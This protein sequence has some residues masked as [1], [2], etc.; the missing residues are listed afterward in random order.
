MSLPLRFIVVLCML[1]G[2]VFVSCGSSDSGNRVVVQIPS[3]PKTLHPV[4]GYDA[5]RLL[6][7]YY[8]HQ[9]MTMLD[10]ISLEHMPLLARDLPVVSEDR[11]TYSYEVAPDATWHDGAPITAADVIF[12]IKAAMCPLLSNVAGAAQFNH[13]NGVSLYPNDEKRFNL[14]MKDKFSDNRYIMDAVHVLDKRFFD[15][16][17]LLDDIRVSFIS[18]SS[19]VVASNPKMIEWAQQYGDADYGRDPELLRGGSGPYIVSEWVPNQRVVL[20]KAV[21]YWGENEEHP[22]HRQY[23]D[24]MVFKAISDENAIEL[25][26]KQQKI[27]VALNIPTRT[28]DR[29]WNSETVKEFYDMES[30]LRDVFTYIGYNMRPD[31]RTH[32]PIFSD[33]AVR[34]AFGLLSPMDDLIQEYQSGRAKRTVSPVNPASYYYNDTIP[35]LSFDP[36]SAASLL[37]AAGWVDTDGDLIRDKEINGERIALSIKLSFPAGQQSFAD[38][39]QRIAEEAAKVG[40][41]IE[42]DPIDFNLLISNMSKHNFDAFFA[43]STSPLVGFDFAQNWTTSSWQAGTNHTGFGSPETDSMIEK[44]RYTHGKRARKLLM[45]RIQEAIYYEQPVL[46]MYNSTNDIAIHR[47]F[48]N[49]EVMPTLPYVLLNNLKLEQK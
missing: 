43:A 6:V 14:L 31:G 18:D 7:L 11:L 41:T 37:D 19:Q 46:F 38:M 20:K 21:P 48:S 47:R 36:D 34:L 26:I 33:Q 22:I 13:I 25:Q 35:P 17:G 10:P 29:L 8:T 23:P 32:K 1:I 5:A 16:E 40:F 4:E 49:G 12:S 28:F 2:T 27:D 9:T 44:L 42:L 45:D 3:E 24:Q 30:G 39:I 15:P